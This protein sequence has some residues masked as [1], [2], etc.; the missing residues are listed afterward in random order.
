M[1]IKNLKRIMLFA[2]IFDV[3]MLLFEYRTIQFGAFL[4]R[5][6]NL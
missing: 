4:P 6:E 2:V 1:G 5:N 3:L